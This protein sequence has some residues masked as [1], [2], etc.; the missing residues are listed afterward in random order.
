[1]GLD[2]SYCTFLPRC[3]FSN[4]KCNFANKS[5]G[6][7]KRAAQIFTDVKDIKSDWRIYCIEFLLADE[8][9]LVATEAAVLRLLIV[10]ILVSQRHF[11]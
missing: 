1:M 3:T 2:F 4:P 7:G 10:T 9:R 8:G 5:F 6:R 11:V